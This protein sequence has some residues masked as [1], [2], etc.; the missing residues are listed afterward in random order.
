MSPAGSLPIPVGWIFAAVAGAVLALLLGIPT[1]RLRD[2]FL[3][4]RDH[5][6][7]RDPAQHCQFR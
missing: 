2:D 7:G 6:R 3:A 5:W 4:I 1:L